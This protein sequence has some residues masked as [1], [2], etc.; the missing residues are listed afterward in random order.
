[1][2]VIEF[3]VGFGMGFIAGWVLLI[4]FLLFLST[5]GSAEIRNMNEFKGREKKR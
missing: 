5:K 2:S 1:M 4:L 3:W